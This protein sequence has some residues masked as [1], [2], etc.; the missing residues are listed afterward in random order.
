MMSL[1]VR[2]RSLNLFH[3]C[4]VCSCCCREIIVLRS[5]YVVVLTL[6]EIIKKRFRVCISCQVQS[7]PRERKNQLMKLPVH[8]SELCHYYNKTFMSD[9][10]NLFTV[11]TIF[12]YSLTHA[13]DS[14][15]HLFSHGFKLQ[16]NVCFSFH[17][18]DILSQPH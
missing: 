11:Y 6:P 12:P 8:A 10:S 9:T 1:Q 3:Y 4:L 14:K 17:L 15:S 2:K 18:K 7:V 5:K 16:L 13:C